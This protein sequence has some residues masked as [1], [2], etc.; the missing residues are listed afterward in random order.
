MTSDPP[1]TETNGTPAIELVGVSKSYGPKQAVDALSLSVPAG[2]LFA[3]LGPN[4]AGKTT[5]IKMLCGLLFPSAGT[6]RVHGFDVQ[7][8]GAQARQVIS[9]VPDQPYLYEKLSGRE[10][11]EFILDMYG[12]EPAYGQRRIREMIEL[13]SL[14]DF[15]DDLCETYSH[16]MKQRTVFAAA[17]LHEPKVLI[18]DEPMVGLDPRSVRLM[19]DLLRKQSAAGMTVFM[20]THSLDMAQELAQRIGII[21]RG[22]LIGLGTLEGLRKQ[23][24]LDGTLEDV[25]LKLTQEAAAD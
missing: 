12:M 21:D 7:Q 17:L 10:F 22:R 15:V 18:V 20:S 4:G 25:F 23:A 2:E 3:F 11:M 13:F 24:A 19:K 8:E 14:E 9:Y 16:G 1:A 6:M 5:T